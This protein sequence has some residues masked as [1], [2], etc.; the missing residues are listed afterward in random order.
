MNQFSLVQA[1]DR[2]SEGVI[3]AV[4]PTANRRFDARFGEPLAI[5]HDDVLRT[6]VGVAYQLCIAAW[7]PRVK[8]LFKRIENG[9]RAHQRVDAPANDP[10][11]KRVD[12]D[13]GVQPALPPRGVGEVREP[14]LVWPRSVELAIDQIQRARGADIGDGRANTLAS[15]HATQTQSPHQSL[16][17]AGS[18]LDALPDHL[19]PDLIRAVALLVGLPHTLDLALRTFVVYRASTAPRRIEKLCGTTPIARRL[20]PRD[21]ADRHDPESVEILIDEG[22]LDFRWR[23]SSAWAKNALANSRISLARRNSFFSRSRV[24]RRSRS[25]VVTPPRSP[26]SIWSRLTQPNIVWLDEPVIRAMFSTAAH[27]DGCSPRNARTRRTERSR[28]PGGNWLDLLMAPFSQELE[29]P[30]NPGRVISTS[31]HELTVPPKAQLA[32]KKEF[33]LYIFQALRDRSEVTRLSNS[34]GQICVESGRS[35]YVTGIGLSVLIFFC[36]LIHRPHARSAFRRRLAGS[37]EHLPGSR[38]RLRPT[39]FL[40]QDRPAVEHAG[41]ACS[42]KVTR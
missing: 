29:P 12:N 1:V 9:V 21:V 16:N 38:V 11:S 34:R 31:K 17:G 20:N 4:A 39:N 35:G 25:G 13:R 36:V 14:K 7:S 2:S 24:L 41:L 30:P 18:H 8:R 3:V 28:T 27:S 10:P 33:S 22:P 26:L 42:S 19:V 5:A 23:S 6:S 15:H 32:Q 40:L 37:K